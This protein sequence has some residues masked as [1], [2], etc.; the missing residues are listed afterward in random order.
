MKTRNKIVVAIFLGSI[1]VSGCTSD[2]TSTLQNDLLNL[3]SKVRSLESENS[4]L[5]SK[6]SSLE[7]KLSSLESKVS[8]L[9]SKVRYGY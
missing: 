8:S 7:Y 3:G 4:S 5:R 1:G 6:V 2:T 9:D